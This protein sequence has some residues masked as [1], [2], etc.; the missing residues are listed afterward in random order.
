MNLPEIN[1]ALEKLV[2]PTRQRVEIEKT[3]PKKEEVTVFANREGLMQL[4]AYC[5]DL[6]ERQS[7]GSHYHF[8]QVSVDSADIP[9][10]ITFR[11]EPNQPPEPTAPSG[12]GSS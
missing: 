6:A 1:A 3:G 11:K 9:L 7:E 8:D 10:V 12:R 2:D 5:L 4:A